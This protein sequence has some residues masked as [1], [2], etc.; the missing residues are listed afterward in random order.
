MEDQ[1]GDTENIVLEVLFVF[2]PDVHFLTPRVQN[3][4]TVQKRFNKTV[5]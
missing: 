5:P 2:K 1:G 4:R 3:F